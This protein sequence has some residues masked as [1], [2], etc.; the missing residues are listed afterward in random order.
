MEFSYIEQK[1]ENN[2]RSA[3]CVFVLKKKSNRT[4]QLLLLTAKLVSFIEYK[5]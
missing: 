2:T 1:L 3:H 5:K 4:N